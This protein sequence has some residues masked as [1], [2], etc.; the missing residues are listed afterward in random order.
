MDASTTQRQDA[1]ARAAYL[2]R[3]ATALAGYPDL[4]ATVGAAGPAPCLT[5][6]NIATP[7]MS[8][9]LTVCSHGNGFAFTWSWGEHICDASNPDTAAAAVAYVLAASDAQ[10]G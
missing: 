7:L 3:L 8:E 5:V 2:Q 9:T 10:L 1:R 4:A 6:H